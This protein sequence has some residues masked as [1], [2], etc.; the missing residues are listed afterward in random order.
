MRTCL[1]TNRISLVSFATFILIRPVLTS[2]P[3]LAQITTFMMHSE[4]QFYKPL[5]CYLCFSFLADLVG[6]KLEVKLAE[7]ISGKQ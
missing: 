1:Y 7:I 2:Q 3:V 5:I 6:P 4:K